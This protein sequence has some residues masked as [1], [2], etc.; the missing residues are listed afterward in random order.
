MGTIE[1]QYDWVV[2]DYGA[3]LTT[4]VSGGERD[5]ADGQVIYGEIMAA[6]FAAR[7][8]AVAGSARD[9]Q[10]LTEAAHQHVPGRTGQVSLADNIDYYVHWMRWIYAQAG[11]E[12]YVP[13]TELESARLFMQSEFNRR[14]SGTADAPLHEMLAALSA[15]GIGLGVISNNSG[16]VEDMLAANGI[17]S[18]FAFVIDSAR[19]GIVK[20]DPAIFHLAVAEHGLTGRLL[21]V[22]DSYEADVVG[23][24]A[25]GWD[26]AWLSDE[27]HASPDGVYQIRSLDALPA[28]CGL[29]PV[30]AVAS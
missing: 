1:R 19:V 15:G 4:G 2:F 20:P 14:R 9:L 22:G 25:A 3:T 23:G 5:P 28:L 7:G 6:W 18:C 17:H 26:V 12:G 27:V 30:A 13:L 29:A 11:V 10:A 16:Y 24:R 8:H 21:Y